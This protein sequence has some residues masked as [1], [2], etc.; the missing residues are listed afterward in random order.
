[1]KTGLRTARSARHTR[2]H[3]RRRTSRSCVASD[4][5]CWGALAVIWSLFRYWQKTGY[6]V[7]KP[8][9]RT[10]GRRRRAH[11]VD[12]GTDPPG[13]APDTVRCGDGRR[14]AARSVAARVG[15]PLRDL[16]AVPSCRGATRRTRMVGGTGAAA[17][18]RRRRH[19]QR[20]RYSG[21]H[22]NPRIAPCPPRLDPARTGQRWQAQGDPA[23][24]ALCAGAP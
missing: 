18:Q 2:G 19:Q 6:L 13:P 4:A 9:R 22:S 1:M 11:D 14:T 7:V 12:T 17:P 21:R 15:T 23:A 20:C 3:V 24:V 10:V 5:S 8:R 16:V